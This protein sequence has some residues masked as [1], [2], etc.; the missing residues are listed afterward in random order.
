MSACHRVNTCV[1]LRAD[2]CYIFALCWELIAILGLSLILIVYRIPTQF[3]TDLLE[4][5]SV[6]LNE[7]F[8]IQFWF[9]MILSKHCTRNAR[10]YNIPTC[11]YLH[12]ILPLSA[13]T[14]CKDIFVRR[15]LHFISPHINSVRMKGFVPDICRILTTYNPCH[16]INDYFCSN[17]LPSK[18]Q[19][20]REISNA[21]GERE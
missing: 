6:F 21:I 10:Y 14:I 5:K 8:K 7:S 20:K 15:Y 3:I 19:W 2:T 16:I 1:Y 13:G 4:R 17:S 11:F 18:A 9:Q 12:K